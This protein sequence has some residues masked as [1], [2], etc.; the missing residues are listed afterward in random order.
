MPQQVITFHYELKDEKGTMLDSSRG[1]EPL[2][3]LEGVGQIIPGLEKELLKMAVGQNQQVYVPYEEG[4][5]PYDQGLVVKIPRKNFPAKEIKEGDVFQ[6][7]RREG[8]QLVMVVEITQ[9]T[10]TVDANHPMAGKNLFFTV[11]VTAKR[12]ATV[13]EVSHGHAHGGDGH[14]HH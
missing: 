12:D 7:Q 11:E 9:D 5:G 6:V 13:E 2:S 10:V 8:P 1:A 14:H 3:F 4:Y